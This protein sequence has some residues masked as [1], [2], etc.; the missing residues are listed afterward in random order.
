MA[1]LKTLRRVYAVNGAQQTIQPSD[2]SG[3]TLSDTEYRTIFTV[4]GNKTKGYG[5]GFGPDNRQRGE[6]G[7]ADL[8]L[9]G[10]NNSGNGTDLDGTLRVLIYDDPDRDNP[11]AKS[12]KY[13][14]SLLRS[15][16]TADKQDKSLITGKNNVIAGD[17]S[18]MAVQVKVTS[19]YDGD[20]VDTAATSTEVGLPFAEYRT[21]E[22]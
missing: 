18:F 12:G 5:W 19:P 10:D 11:V 8:D 15:D 22:F 3:T 4:Q 1:G 7:V 16:V 20:S 9:Q 6:L 13:Q 2:L 21:G 17:D 14:L